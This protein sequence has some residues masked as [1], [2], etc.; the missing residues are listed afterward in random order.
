MVP[1]FWFERLLFFLNLKRYNKVGVGVGVGEELRPAFYPAGA[2]TPIVYC[3]RDI[4]V[5][6]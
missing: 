2:Y 4:A 6:E 5:M 1:I 3:F